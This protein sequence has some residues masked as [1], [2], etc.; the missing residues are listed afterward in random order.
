MKIVFKLRKKK[1]TKFG[2]KL[3]Q[4][5]LFYWN[6]SDK[7]VID[8]GILVLPQHFKNQTITK[9]DS[10]CE[11]KNEKL[12]FLKEISD[13][14][15]SKYYKE[16]F[17]HPSTE[18]FA[19]LYK[20]RIARCD[21][22]KSLFDHFEHWIK[23]KKGEDKR[24][25]YTILNSLKKIL[26]GE[27]TLND[28]NNSTLNKIK[29]AW[30]NQPVKKK[31]KI[32][33]T[34]GLLDTTTKKRW[35]S[36]KQ[37]LRAQ[38]RTEYKPNPAYR[39]F[40]LDLPSLRLKDN[41]FYPSFEEFQILYDAIL[42][43]DMDYV[44]NL[45]CL[46][47]WTGLRISDI[48]KVSQSSVSKNLEGVEIIKINTKK[49]KRTTEIPLFAYSKEIIYKRLNN[50]QPLVFPLIESRLHKIWASLL[51]QMPPSFSV[52]EKYYATIGGV[53][54]SYIKPKYEFL[55]FHTSRKFFATNMCSRTSLNNVMAWGC[56]E[57]I[58]AFQ[59]YMGSSVDLK[60]EVKKINKQINLIKKKK[61][62]L[63]PDP[64]SQPQ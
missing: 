33:L 55:T 10:D 53:D 52:D 37:F 61:K 11:A 13:D 4:I 45:Y 29:D 46:S 36:F 30:I 31:R 51:S 62:P 14:I 8:T 22:T 50:H 42:T 41:I 34:H 57:S 43:D 64:S 1:E 25:Y 63:I 24:I 7:K 5:Q 56:W 58:S 19:D 3:C 35:R 21:K 28:L 16:H 47:C 6:D 23:H 17:E 32:N 15:I 26:P 27:I 49:G 2:D 59:R 20:N 9:F 40:E 18:V 39:E 38:E 44:R 12:R 48:Q 60:D 54:K